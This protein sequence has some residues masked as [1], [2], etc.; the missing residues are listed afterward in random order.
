MGVTHWAHLLVKMAPCLLH[1]HLACAALPAVSQQAECM[2]HMLL[3][4]VAIPC[5]VCLTLTPTPFPLFFARVVLL[6]SQA[7]CLLQYMKHT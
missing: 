3:I 1:Q 4:K 6:H 5:C 2:C 7:V